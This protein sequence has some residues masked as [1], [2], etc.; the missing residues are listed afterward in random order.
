M[1]RRFTN[2]EFGSGEY[3]FVAGRRDWAARSC[4]A[5][6]QAGQEENTRGTL[7]LPVDEVDSVSGKWEMGKFTGWE[8]GN[9]CSQNAA[10]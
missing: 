2:A 7:A 8:T 10:V 9:S 1:G 3:S 6:A 5:C 4:P